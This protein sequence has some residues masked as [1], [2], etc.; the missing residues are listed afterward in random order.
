[1]FLFHV[2]PVLAVPG[3]APVQQ[4]RGGVDTVSGPV[5]LTSELRWQPDGN[6][7]ASAGTCLPLGSVGGP[8][9]GTGSLDESYWAAHLEWF[10]RKSPICLRRTR[11]PSVLHHLP[12]R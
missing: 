8:S 6:L 7:R 5:L 4:T 11:R 10:F 12:W 9:V 2:E 3:K 1:M